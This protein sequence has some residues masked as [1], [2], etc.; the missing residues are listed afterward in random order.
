MVLT[1]RPLLAVVLYLLLAAYPHSRK[2]ATLLASI[3]AALLLA[4]AVGWIADACS[5]RSEHDR[6]HNAAAYRS[7]AS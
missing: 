3:A 6:G 5:R 2:H 7:R 1:L 4:R